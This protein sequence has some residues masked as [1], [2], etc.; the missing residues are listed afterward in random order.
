MGTRLYSLSALME[1]VLD[2]F[3]AEHGGGSAA[4][5]AA[6]S[7]AEK[8]RLVRDS[9]EYMLAV[10]SVQLGE[11]DKVALLRQ[12]YSEIFGY[13]A[14][15]ALFAEPDITTISLQGAR[16][17]FVR[18]GHGELTP[19]A[20]NFDDDAHLRR[21][22]DRM[23]ADAGARLSESS[24]MI[25]TG[26]KLGGRRAALNVAAPPYSHVLSVDIRLHPEQPPT[27]DDLVAQDRLTTQAANVLRQIACSAYG[28]AVV[29]EPESGKTTLLNAMLMC[30]ASAGL[31]AVERGGELALEDS[32]RR[33]RPSWPADSQDDSPRTLTTCIAEALSAAPAALV[34]DE[35]RSDEAQAI[36]PLLEM[37]QVPRLIWSVRGVPDAKRLQSAMGMLARRAGFGSSE[38][39]VHALYQR[40]PFVITT[41]RIREKLRLFS[42]AEWQSRIDTDYPDYVMLYQFQ[43]GAARPTGSQ[44]ARWLD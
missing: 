10:E 39:R 25:E 12:A 28:Y 11:T 36:G 20:L 17:A 4:F 26:L 40:L 23:L 5:N 9:A 30:A 41:A 16:R 8:M 6:V 21:I 34:L 24:G 31:A 38:E 33:F 37:P 27:L 3:F 44:F 29:G 18:R 22:V 1:R 43:D 35:V 42:I 19:V 2:Q 7:G 13:G 32:V 14:L 15:D